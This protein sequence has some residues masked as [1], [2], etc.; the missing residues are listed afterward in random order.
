MKNQLYLAIVILLIPTVTIHAQDFQIT[1]ADRTAWY[2]LLLFMASGVFVLWRDGKKNKLE[3]QRL[4]NESK[5]KAETELAKQLGRTT[6]F[7]EKALDI[8][9]GSQETITQKEAQILKLEEE[10]SDLELELSDIRRS[11]HEVTSKYTQLAHENK[12][13]NELNIK[14]MELRKQ[15]D[16]YRNELERKNEQLSTAL[17]ELEV[18]KRVHYGKTLPIP[19]LDEDGNPI[20]PPDNPPAPS[21]A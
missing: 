13:I 6:Q 8:F 5:A 12:K 3:K 19:E 1:S 10:K 21:P 20:I 15:R 7:A 11:L 17:I 18:F 4:D 14:I 2:G 9:E 16:Q